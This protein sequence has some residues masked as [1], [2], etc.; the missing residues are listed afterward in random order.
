MNYLVF[1]IDNEGAQALRD[2][3]LAGH[4]QHVEAVMDQLVLAGPCPGKDP[5]DPTQ[6]SLLIFEADSEDEALSLFKR[7]PYF[8]AG[9]W[10]SW[11]VRAF[12]PVA[13]QMVGGK[14]W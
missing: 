14:T 13:G 6:G 7:D 5:G 4:L 1:C 8:S 12:L 9:V 10:K 2:E 3:H 11:D